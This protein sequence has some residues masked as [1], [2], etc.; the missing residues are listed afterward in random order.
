MSRFFRP[1]EGNRPYVFISYSHRDSDTVLETISG[2][3]DRKLRLWYDEGIPSGGDWPKNIEQHMRA[4]SAVLFFLSE[5][6]LASPNCYLEIKTAVEADKPVLLVPIEQ[7]TPNEAWTALLSRADRLPEQND[8]RSADAILSW[9]VLKRAFYRKWT[10]ALRREWFGLGA[11]V[12]LLAAAAIGLIALLNGWISLGGDVPTPT[13]TASLTPT[14]APTETPEPKP[15]PTVD[16]S[17]FPVQFPDAQQEEAVRSLLGKK[18]GDV[19]RPELAAITELY[20][21]GNQVARS[22]DKVTISQDGTLTV[23]GADVR[24]SGKVSDLSLIGSMVYL[25]RLALIDQP[26]KDLSKLNGLV[27]LKELY[28]SDNA[29]S[30]LSA[31]TDLPRLESLHIEH[32]NVCD[33]TVLDAFPSLKTVTVSADMLPLKWTEEKPFTVILVP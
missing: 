26:L 27:L 24:L 4:C 9:K 18:E 13:A 32:T 10:D 12:L 1:Y 21:C 28:L 14:A 15:T 2:L 33:L 30:D 16:P 17:V 11:A 6:A 23:N 31:L 25:E 22:M 20:L 7:T 19:L 8:P 3:N 5:T 29:I